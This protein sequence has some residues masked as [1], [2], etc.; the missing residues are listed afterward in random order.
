MMNT[1][2]LFQA[3]ALGASIQLCSAAEVKPPL[4]FTAIFNGKDLTGWYAF[5]GD[6]RKIFAMSEEER[7]QF[8][9]KSMEDARKH[10][11][12]ENAELVNDGHGDYLT[13]AKD[14][15]DVELL[16]D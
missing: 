7:A 1:R 10:W 6:P 4:G 13:T 16:I 14:Y 3:I 8:R 11:T 9:E 2:T 15:G 12:V 5:N